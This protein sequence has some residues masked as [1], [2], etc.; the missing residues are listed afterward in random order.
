[1]V[2]GVVK[3]QAHTMPMVTPQR[4]AEKGPA[5]P[6]A[7]MAPVITWVVLTDA[8]KWVARKMLKAEMSQH[9]HHQSVVIL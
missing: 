6:T 3:T 5:K 8:P 4:T 7:D 2:A 9:R 1:V